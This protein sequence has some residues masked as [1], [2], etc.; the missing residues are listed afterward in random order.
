MRILL[1]E[2]F[3]RDL[4]SDYVGHQCTHVISLGWAGTLNGELLDKAEQ[5]GFDVLITFDHG[6]PR[7][8]DIAARKI[9]IYVVKPEGQGVP[10][11]QALTGEILI[12]LQNCKPGQVLTFTNR[13][14]KQPR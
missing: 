13:S 10:E 7:D 8:H 5:A 9:A 6:I 4:V 11:T 12:A 14:R 3:P 1:D 2:N